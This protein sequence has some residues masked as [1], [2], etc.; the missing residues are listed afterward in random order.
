MPA[1]KVG[2]AF[3]NQPVAPD[4]PPDVVDF[5]SYSDGKIQLELNLN[6]IVIVAPSLQADAVAP[7]V[8]GVQLAFFWG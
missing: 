2:I 7:P 6:P 8:P 1:F 5:F 3:S 4:V